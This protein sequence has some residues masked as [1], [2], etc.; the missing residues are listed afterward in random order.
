V[1]GANPGCRRCSAGPRFQNCTARKGGAVLA[2]KGRAPM[3]DGT[4]L[5]IAATG[6]TQVGEV[7]SGIRAD[8]GGPVSK[9]AYWLVRPA[10]RV[11]S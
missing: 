11:G 3:R 2:P 5:L 7:T 10:R 9:W 6:G 8:G 1:R 4:P